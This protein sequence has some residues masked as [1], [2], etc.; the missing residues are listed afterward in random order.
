[1]KNQRVL[2]KVSTAL[3]LAV[4][5][6]CA[7]EEITK[8]P[9][10]VQLLGADELGRDTI[11]VTNKA[12][13]QAVKF[14]ANGDWHASIPK[15]AKEW[16]SISPESGS[17]SAEEEIDATVTIKAN[18]LSTDRVATISF[19][20]DKLEQKAQLFIAQSRLWTMLVSSNKSVIN[21]NGG[22][23]VFS[24]NANCDWTW[25]LDE[26]AK[27]W[28]TVAEESGSQLVVSA[29]PLANISDVKSG[30]V[31][32]QSVQD[33]D[34][35]YS[36]EVGQ[37]DIDLSMGA[38]M[39]Y[40]YRTGSSAT[41]NVS[42]TNVA[43]WTPSTD[44][45]WITATK[46]G[47]DKVKVSIAAITSGEADRA[48]TVTLTATD[49]ESVVA[50]LSVG[51]LGH[52][53]PVADL[54][55]VEFAEDGS[56]K[57]ISAGNRP[58]K[59]VDGGASTI[60]FFPTYGIYGPKFTNAMAGTGKSY[61]TV[62][63]DDAMKTA[64][65][66]GYTLECICMIDIAHNGSETKAFSS[67]KSGGTALMIGSG[68]RNNLIFLINVPDAGSTASSWKFVESKVKPEAGRY[69]HLVGTWDIKTGI[70]AVYV[71]GE[72]KA[73]ITNL[74]RPMRWA[75][76]AQNYFTIGANENTATATNGGWHGDVPMARIYDKAVSAEDVQALYLNSLASKMV[77]Q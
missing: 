65:E 28:L 24:I 35:K 31:S 39:I 43:D 30:V 4:L 1:M 16:V 26:E 53:A 17:T 6:A 55:D 8:V 33:P 21:K 76:L 64:M 59:F 62:D 29:G 56:A 25:S 66:D 54:F 7:A 11:S 60:D 14:T 23:I 34:L 38:S 63:I 50:K 69:Y 27:T 70:A 47:P 72:L 2:L 52:A 61:Y 57:D 77:I 9:A 71:D 49:D 36:F 15:E 13:T 10:K 67:T 5:S 48:G 74:A 42:T 73:Q 58:V 37:K 19:V 68:A 20:C 45:D 75:T 22:E 44:C 3:A 12:Q 18:E 32:F 51:Q 46:E 40:S 41:I